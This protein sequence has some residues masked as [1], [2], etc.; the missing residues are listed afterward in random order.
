V[1]YIVELKDRLNTFNKQIIDA[2]NGGRRVNPNTKTGVTPMKSSNEPEATKVIEARFVLSADNIVETT[3]A[4][5][6]DVIHEV[7]KDEKVL[8]STVTRPLAFAWLSGHNAA[9]VKHAKGAGAK[10]V[11]KG[12]DGKGKEPGGSP[13]K[14]PKSGAV[15]PASVEHSVK[16]DKDKPASVP[17]APPQRTRALL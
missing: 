3:D 17:P 9:V 2:Y 7:V 4:A 8:F 10:D 5:T 15:I 6:G 12:E 1:Q 16:S 13:I 14:P 11:A